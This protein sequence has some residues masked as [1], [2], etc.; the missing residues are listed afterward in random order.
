MEYN[1]VSTDKWKGSK[2]IL[3]IFYYSAAEKKISFK[4]DYHVTTS[5]FS[6][7]VNRNAHAN[8]SS[9]LLFSFVEGFSDL[10]IVVYSVLFQL[11]FYLFTGFW[12]KGNKIR[13]KKPHIVYLKK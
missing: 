9:S 8:T 5:T 12:A 10:L 4:G 11:V 2:G 13:K 6:G 3:C 1:V 7:D